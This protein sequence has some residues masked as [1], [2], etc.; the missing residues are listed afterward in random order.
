MPFYLVEG[1]PRTDRHKELKQELIDDAFV[2]LRPFGQA[3]SKSLRNARRRP[4]GQIAWEEED[5]CSPPLAEE[6]AAVL[7]EY[8][9]VIEVKQVRRGEGWSRIQDLPPL[10]PDLAKESIA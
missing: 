1:T 8:F 7:D 2:D 5:Y 3:L 4:D 10:F 9:E 6:R